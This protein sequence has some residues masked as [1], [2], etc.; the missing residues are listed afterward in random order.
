MTRE[1]Q[2]IARRFE[3]AD[4][5]DSRSIPAIRTSAE[6]STRSVVIL[7]AMVLA[8]IGGPIAVMALSSLLEQW[9]HDVVASDTVRACISESKLAD[10]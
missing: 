7:A 4:R 8:S 5:R 9:L 10:R 6:T 3:H 2:V 1:L